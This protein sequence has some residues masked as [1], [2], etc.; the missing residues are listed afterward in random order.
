MKAA[1]VLF[2]LSLSLLAPLASHAQTEEPPRHELSM[3]M[4]PGFLDAA[5][6]SYLR[7]G[8]NASIAIMR[9][10]YVP[11]KDRDAFVKDL[12]KAFS[13]AESDFNRLV[14]IE[15]VL[16]RKVSP[17]YTQYFLMYGYEDGVLFIR[18]DIYASP[19]GHK[20]VNY[21]LTRD[22]DAFLPPLR[23][24]VELD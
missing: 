15:P 16:V 17:S 12:G 10:E 22:P 3:A 18:Y 20:I 1:L 24:V 11:F 5:A 19:N 13:L 9:E 23:E 4:L 6:N 2:A 14:V 8:R 21:A 7:S